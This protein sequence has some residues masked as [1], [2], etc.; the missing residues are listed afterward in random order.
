MR[1]LPWLTA[2]VC[3]LAAVG[4][5]HAQSP[6]PVV[7]VPQNE[8]ISREPGPH[9]GTGMT[10]AYRYSD[11]APGR[12]MEFRKRALHPGASIGEHVLTHDE[13]YYVLSG[14]G[15]LTADGKVTRIGPGTAVYIY[16]GNNVGIRQVGKEDLVL[17]VSYP[18][19]TKVDQK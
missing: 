7:I 18:T 9:N 13:V 1:I 3:L 5:A 17:I 16:T 2:A 14:M 19:K 8:V 12:A 6:N 15:D 11:R 10:T 4:L